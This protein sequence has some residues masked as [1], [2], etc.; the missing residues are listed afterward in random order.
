MRIFFFTKK[1]LSRGMTGF[2]FLGL[3]AFIFLQMIKPQVAAVPA[4][5]IYQGNSGQKTVALCINVDWGEEFLPEM[6]KTFKAND[7][8]VTFFVT[9]RWAEKNPDLL[10][11]MH[12]E[13]HSI[14]NHGYKHVHFNN[15]SSEQAR[16]QIVKGGQIIYKLTGEESVYFAPPYGEFN[17]NVVTVSENLHY[18]LIM[19]SIDTIDWQKPPADTII[20]RVMN[21]LHND[22][23]ILMHPTQPTSEALPEL[24]TQITAAGYQMKTLDQIIVTDNEKKDKN[25]KTDR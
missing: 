10:R 1:K 3:L 13:G 21:Q 9:G 15:L 8:K 23:I 18:K 7:T 22:A 6:L 17:N 16:E 4:Q 24:M 20:K 14:Q 2:L 12:E 11:Q 19:W 5:A 25:E